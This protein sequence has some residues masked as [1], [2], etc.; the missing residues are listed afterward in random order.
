MTA[1]S[2][3]PTAKGGRRGTQRHIPVLLPEVLAA[4]APQTGERFIDGTFG[5]GGYTSALLDSAADV[6]VL[7]ID[8][9]PTAVAAGQS[10]AGESGGR[11]SLVNGTFGNLDHIAHRHGFA[12]ADGVVLDIG[13]MLGY[14]RGMFP[15]A[16][17][18]LPEESFFAVPFT[19]QEMVTRSFPVGDDREQL[20]A[21]LTAS[22][23]GDAL[24][25]DARREGDTVRFAYQSVVLVAVKG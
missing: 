15:A 16:G 14:L 12:P 22:V 1:R 24:G 9:D 5:A 8:R 17:L 11:L 20:R 18:P 13:S 7:A 23:D 10:L 3:P 2:G 4:L 25:M 21:T 6:R 19:L